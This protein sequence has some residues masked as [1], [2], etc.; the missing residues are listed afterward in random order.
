MKESERKNTVGKI[1]RVAR[2]VF[3]ILL[4]VALF[5][6][7]LFA[8]GNPVNFIGI[9]ILAPFAYGIFVEKRWG[10][11]GYGIIKIIEAVIVSL[12]V[13]FSSGA[14]EALSSYAL[15]F[16]DLMLGIFA[17]AIAPSDDEF[18]Q[19]L[20]IDK[21]QEVQRLEKVD[22]NLRELQELEGES[23]VQFAM[24]LPDGWVCVCGTKNTK[25]ALNCTNCHRNR[26]YVLK[27]WTEKGNHKKQ[28]G[29]KKPPE[30]KDLESCD[31]EKKQSKAQN[32]AMVCPN[33]GAEVFQNYKYCEKCGAELGT[34]SNVFKAEKEETKQE[35]VEM[36]DRVEV[37]QRY[38]AE[39]IEEPNLSS[40]KQPKEEIKKV[41]KKPERSLSIDEQETPS[42]LIPFRKGSKWGYCD[43]NRNLVIPVVFDEAGRFSEGLAPVK[44]NG[45][46]G[47]IDLKGLLCIPA[48]YEKVE[49]F[50]GGLAN[51]SQNKR[52]GYIDKKG[53]QYWED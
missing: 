51:V 3:R 38:K 11:I 49:P 45:K 40:S 7:L 48:I 36:N 14:Y 24:E 34:K 46:W 27:R 50:L 23:A 39:I 47:F 21:T 10:H 1:K 19:E 15:V 25:D 31:K 29:N 20:T 43:E 16:V 4:V 5:I 52:K 33:C 13:A 18:L 12:R 53:N 2:S 30:N 44:I 41:D 22:E 9:L 26:D 42:L 32:S 37:G 17:I 35:Q 8:L 6:E 28:T